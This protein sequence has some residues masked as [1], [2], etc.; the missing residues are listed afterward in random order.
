MKKFLI[1]VILFTFIGWSLGEVIVRTFHVTADIPRRFIDEDGIQKYVPAQTGYWTGGTHQWRV[2]E[3]GWV[4]PLP[5]SQKNL[6]VII[7]DSFIENFMNPEDSHQSVLL[8]N[9]LPEYNFI[10]AARSGVSLIEAFEISKSMQSMNPTLNLIYVHDSDFLESI[11]EFKKNGGITQFDPVAKKIIPGKIKSAILKK[12][13]YSSKFLYYLYTRQRSHSKK[14]TPSKDEV[15]ADHM[16]TFGEL[17]DYCAEDYNVSDKVLVFRPSSDPQLEVLAREKGFQTFVLDWT[18][19]K[20][21][22]FEHDKHWTPY[23]HQRAA[24]QIASFIEKQFTPATNSKIDFLPLKQLTSKQPRSRERPLVVQIT[25]VPQTLCVILPVV[26]Q[27]LKDTG[28]EVRGITSEG[29]DFSYKKAVEKLEIE[30]AT[31]PLSRRIDPIGD[32]KAL[33][34]LV[35]ILRKWKPD[36]VHCHTP[37]AGLLGGLAGWIARSPNRLYTV[38]GLP[39]VTATGLTRMLLI[40]SDKIACAV[41][42][43]VM[44]VSKSVLGELLECGIGKQSKMSVVCTGSAQGVDAENRFNPEKI[45]ATNQRDVK[46]ELGIPPGANVVGFIGRLTVDKGIKQLWEIWQMTRDRYPDLH[47][48]IIGPDNEPRGDVADIIK[49]F[50]KDGRVHVTGRVEKIEQYLLEM[51]VF[52]FPSHREGFSNAVLE[53][54]AM[55]LPTITFDAVGCRDGVKNEVTGYIVPLKDVEAMK[56][57]LWELLDDLSLREKLGKTARQWVMDEFRPIDRLTMLE[58]TYNQLLSRESQEAERLR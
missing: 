16:K 7:G 6:V 39:H 9:E 32:L 25:T 48:V 23:G 13:L 49:K 35:K 43:R 31:A 19:D 12:I 54:A 51:D 53:A 41:A 58:D 27:H 1:N 15:S 52:L 55:A 20:S 40:G 29:G 45:R 42:H 30:I 11:S 46:K 17:L 57:R 22:R 47:L 50:K 24:K 3:L 33:Y 56:R 44:V 26:V 2:N 14:A 4:G 37:K 5:K 38:R 18:N 28:F 8:K 10:E 36:I 21:W 34:G